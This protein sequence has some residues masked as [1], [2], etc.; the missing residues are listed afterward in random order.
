MTS[1]CHRARPKPVAW[2]ARPPPPRAC[3]N[4]AGSDREGADGAGWRDRDLVRNAGDQ[5]SGALYCLGAFTARHRIAVLLVWTLFAVAMVGWVRIAGAKTNN[6]LTLPGTDSQH[7]FDI[8]AEEFPP[9]QNGANPFVFEAPHGKLTDAEFK[10][11]MD[12]TAAA[13]AHGPHV[14][15]AINPISKKGRE[16][17]LLSQ[18]GT[19]AFDPVLLDVNSGFITDRLA[20]DILAVT[21]P[22]RKAGIK[23]AVGGSIGSTLSAPDTKTSQI[24]GNVAA[25]VIFALVFGSLVAMGTP[26]VTAIIALAVATSTIGLLGHLIGIPS[27]GPTLAVMIGLGV[28]IDYA[29]FLVTKHLDLLD[30]GVE[31]GESIARA[32]SSSGTAVV[33][34]GTTVVIALLSLAVAGIPLITSLGVSAAI[35]VFCAVIA[36]ITLLPAVLSLLGGTIRRLRIPSFMRPKHRPE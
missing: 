21:D 8:L 28:G 32:M 5:V 25:M 13:L 9:Q 23:V 1:S 4:V 3:C 11:P 35:A 14:Y 27:V 24:L 19:I 18:D 33:F 29:L 6:N 15:S 34:A 20:N 10:A 36:S 31:V 17:G 26:I 16:A 7:A 2:A 22:A 12:A 30:S